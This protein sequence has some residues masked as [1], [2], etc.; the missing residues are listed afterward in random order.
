MAF[1]FAIRK[2]LVIRSLA[3]FENARDICKNMYYLWRGDRRFDALCLVGLF[4]VIRRHS[5]IV[6]RACTV[7]TG[8]VVCVDEKRIAASGKTLEMSATETTL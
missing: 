8:T 1:A 6:A 3:V 5:L 2:Q 4:F 7:P